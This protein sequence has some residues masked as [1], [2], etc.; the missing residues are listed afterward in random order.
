MED[1]I[2]RAKLA[3]HAERH[4][5]MIKVMKEVVSM[6]ANLDTEARNLLS[7]AF[8]NAI[9][10]R[11]NAW[12][13]FESVRRKK[14]DDPNPVVGKC[15]G[16]YQDQVEKELCD[17]AGEIIALIDN[18]LVGAVPEDESGTKVFYLKMKGDYY[19]YLAEFQCVGENKAK[20]GDAAKNGAQ[21]AYQDAEA[22]CESISPT[23]PIRLGFALNYSVFLYEVLENREDAC[24]MAKTA[25]DN[26][27]SELDN[28][29]EEKYKDSTQIMQLLRDNLTLWTSE[30][31]DPGDVEDL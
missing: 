2:F 10:T 6:D 12:R 7:V 25:F 4:D 18:T 24:K 20:Y 30:A 23:H 13:S 5:D 8:K 15:I 31:E 29:P 16:I 14:K 17:I 26:A 1:L 21:S 22:A 28:L 19:R 9:G 3:E 11:R 27:I